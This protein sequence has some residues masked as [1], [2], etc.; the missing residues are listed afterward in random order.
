MKIA[1]PL[2]ATVK[3]RAFAVVLLTFQPFLPWLFSGR[4]RNKK[5]RKKAAKSMTTEQRK[6]W[7]NL[8]FTRE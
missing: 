4:G 5:C 6:N 7:H 1:R 2:K 3:F 8:P